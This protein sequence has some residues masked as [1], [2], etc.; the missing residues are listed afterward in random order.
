MPGGQ[1]VAF[2]SGFESDPHDC[3]RASRVSKSPR[4]TRSSPRP[5]ILS[6]I[7]FSL[8]GDAQAQAGKQAQGRK[9]GRNR[10]IGASDIPFNIP[11]DTDSKAERDRAQAKSYAQQ[12]ANK[13]STTSQLPVGC[14]VWAGILIVIYLLEKA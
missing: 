12:A 14:L 8:P 11:T 9:A 4:P 13:Q 10:D 3:N 1:W 2:D 6:D 7:P 5:P